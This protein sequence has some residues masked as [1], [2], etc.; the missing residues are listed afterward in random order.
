MRRA[1]DLF[2]WLLLLSWA[3][4][5]QLRPIE[6]FDLW[7]H[8]KVGRLVLDGQ[9]LPT[10]DEWSATAAGRPFIAHE[11][12]AGA[13]LEWLSS[14]TGGIGLT[15]LLVWFAALLVVIVAV[16]LK[17]REQS[18]VAFWLAAAA[19]AMVL[20]RSTARPHLFSLLFAALLVAA[21]AWWRQ[22]RQWRCLLWLVPLV[23]LWANLH[24]AFLLAPVMLVAVG[25]AALLAARFPSLHRAP[26]EPAVKYRDAL[27]P[28]VTAALCVV[29]GAMN[30]YGL[31]LYAF[32]LEMAFG[33]AYLKD[34]ISEWLPPFS[35][36]HIGNVN[37]W[38]FFGW[39]S[40]LIVVALVERR[41]LSALELF[42][43]AA[44]L[45]LSFGAIRFVPYAALFGLPVLV[46][47][48]DRRVPLRRR[49][50]LEVV[51]GVLLLLV[52]LVRGP[53]FGGD[54]P[55]GIGVVPHRAAGM[56]E[57]MKAMGI[58]GVVFHEYEDGGYLLYAGAPELVPVIDARVDV[59]GE[60]LTK[61]YRRA[62]EVPGA[63]LE[64]A[65]RHDVEAVLLENPGRATREIVQPLLDDPRFAVALAPP[66]WI[67]LR[68]VPV[69]SDLP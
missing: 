14:S 17:G 28:L 25:V 50:S 1:A 30:P 66:G 2:P 35:S 23:G 21:L 69:D 61:E 52:V 16:T 49:P 51:G 57:A 41:R 13:L 10:V 53:G 68:R 19:L 45:W 63:L 44:A 56:V 24:G 55:F 18:P 54:P 20:A 26:D 48:L 40:L 39:S 42:P 58:R 3:A 11:W 4:L 15:A 62:R 67:L 29:A 9:P 59:Y 43:L 33:N 12:L 47:W 5:T 38:L 46:R 37:T 65:E 34:F 7:L 31:D 27:Q 60:E 6:D 32:S 8:L 22:R 64:Y 36:A